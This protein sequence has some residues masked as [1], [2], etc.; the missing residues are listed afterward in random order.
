[1][2]PGDEG[3]GVPPGA[4]ALPP[5]VGVAGRGMLL[6]PMPGE[7]GAAGLGAAGAIGAAGLGAAG[8]GAAGLGAVGMTD[9]AGAGFLAGVLRAAVLRAVAFFALVFL[10]AV[11]RAVARFAVLRAPVLRAVLRAVRAVLRA[12]RAVFRAVFRAPLRAPVFLLVVRFFPLV[13]VAMASAPILLCCRTRPLK[14]TRTCSNHAF[15]LVQ[16][17]RP[18]WR[19]N[20]FFHY[21]PD[22]SRK[23]QFAV[24]RLAK[25]S[26]LEAAAYTARRA[27]T[28]ELRPGP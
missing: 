18:A 23:L 16:A 13:L 12:V 28:V 8:A 3:R 7:G 10:A 1:M 22:R 14:R 15:P 2:P 17:C 21:I 25:T 19:V 26:T 6:P 4:G 27:G 11:F 5:P 20:S 9:A 24:Q